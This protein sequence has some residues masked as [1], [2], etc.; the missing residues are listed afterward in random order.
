MA[1]VTRNRAYLAIYQSGLKDRK[2]ILKNKLKYKEN[3]H[4]KKQR[5]PD[6]SSM[7]CAVY[8]GDKCLLV[9]SQGDRE[10]D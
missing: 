10:Q 7:N 1:D 5:L 8:Y 4:G 3:L 9:S 6:S 2:D